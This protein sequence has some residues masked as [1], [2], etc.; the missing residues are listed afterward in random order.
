MIC[1]TP[2]C[3]QQAELKP[4]GETRVMNCVSYSLSNDGKPVTVQRNC[5]V[6]EPIT[7]YC[8]FCNKKR[9]KIFERTSAFYRKQHGIDAPF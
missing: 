1:K 6:L 4:T 3:N 5:P 9:S 7:G 8:Y 2:Y